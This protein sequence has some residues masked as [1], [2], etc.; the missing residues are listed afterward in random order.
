MV[1]PQGLVDTGRR[2]NRRR[3]VLAGLFIAAT[4]VA[5]ATLP[6]RE[7]LDAF[8]GW[9]AAHPVTGRALFVASC[10]LLSVLMVPG[11]ILMMAG[12][13]LFGLLP[14]L[15]LVSIGIGLGSGAA[16]LMARTL[17]REPLAARFANDRRY[18]VIDG[19]VARKGFQIVALSRLSLIMP[20]NLLNL[21]YGLTRIPLWKLTVA[22]WI[23]MT[24]SVVLYTYLGSIAG[25][26]DAV[27][28]GGM[29]GRAGKL[30]LVSGLVMVAVVTWIIHR[31]A[32]RALRQELGEDIEE[33]PEK[34]ED[35][36]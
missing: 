36:T 35:E 12:G 11:S 30:I 13:F 26:I 27:F 6:L 9:S 20:F 18:A 16:G 25:N 14:A 31:T 23:G 17:A 10:I 5:G 34:T 32:T 29:N 1:Q 33:T 24:P 2:S 21:I 28:T 19:A 7:W 3:L 8:A 4:I 15:P 22:T